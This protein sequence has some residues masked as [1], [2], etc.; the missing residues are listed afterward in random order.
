MDCFEATRVLYA[1]VGVDEVPDY[2]DSLLEFLAAVNTAVQ[3]E[4]TLSDSAVDSIED[5]ARR[6]LR[7]GA[8]ST[9]ETLA[10]IRTLRDR[11]AVAS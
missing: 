4:V 3:N 2:R 9:Q 1:A 10:A 11:H 6:M 8:R 7:P 5:L